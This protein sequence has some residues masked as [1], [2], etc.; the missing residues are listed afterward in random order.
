V[1]VRIEAA[2]ALAAVD[3]GGAA[4]TEVLNELLR[5]DDD[6]LKR[7]AIDIIGVLKEKAV[8]TVPALIRVLGHPKPDVRR[9]AAAALGLIGPGAGAAVPALAAALKDP[10]DE[11]RMEA[12]DALEFM[13]KAAKE[14]VPALIAALGDPHPKVRTEVEQTLEVIRDVLGPGDTALR[15]KIVG[16]LKQKKARDAAAGPTP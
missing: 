1:V 5:T 12:A 16:A 10:A 9:E 3:D 4:S 8:G 7:T 15:E 11:V 14:A 13:P 6:G 2:R